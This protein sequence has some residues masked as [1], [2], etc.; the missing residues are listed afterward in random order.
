MSWSNVRD[1]GNI[2]LLLSG[3]F[4]DKRTT[5]LVNQHATHNVVELRATMKK[6]IQ[7][8]LHISYSFECLQAERVVARSNDTDIIVMCIH[9]ATKCKSIK[10][11]WVCLAEE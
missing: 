1:L 5:L 11:L 10:E 3:A 6:Q 4:S 7:V 9:Y 2:K 8:I